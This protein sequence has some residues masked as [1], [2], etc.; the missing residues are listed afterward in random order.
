MLK[1][2]KLDN[3]FSI[4]NRLGGGENLKKLYIRKVEKLSTTAAFGQAIWAAHGFAS[5]KDWGV[6]VSGLKGNPHRP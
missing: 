6:F 2:S 4:I 5:G 1:C 3:F